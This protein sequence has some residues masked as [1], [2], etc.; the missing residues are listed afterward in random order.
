MPPIRYEKRVGRESMFIVALLAKSDELSH[1][2]MGTRC[3]LAGP[4]CPEF[5]RVVGKAMRR[6]FGDRARMCTTRVCFV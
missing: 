5:F 6:Q 4:N 2:G 3:V 1:Y